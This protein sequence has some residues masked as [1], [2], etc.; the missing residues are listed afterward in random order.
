M[1]HMLLSKTSWW[2]VL[3]QVLV[4]F[5]ICTVV[6]FVRLVC[7][8]VVTALPGWHRKALGWPVCLAVERPPFRI[9]L[10]VKPVSSTWAAVNILASA[11]AMCLGLMR[12]CLVMNRVPP[13]T[14]GKSGPHAVH[15]VVRIAISFY[16]KHDACVY[17]LAEC[18]YPSVRLTR[19]KSSLQPIHFH[20]LLPSWSFV[21][22][23]TNTMAPQDWSLESH[24]RITSQSHTERL[25]ERLFLLHNHTDLWGGIAL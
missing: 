25:R 17:R 20:P 5:C 2:L 19:H 4:V 24:S 21:C 23:F 6:A 13:Y 11:L 1:V 3:W 9:E 16:F 14:I 22:L 18:K 8:T 7:I 10:D 12:W 15:S